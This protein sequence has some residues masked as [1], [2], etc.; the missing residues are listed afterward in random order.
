MYLPSLDLYANLG[1][2]AGTGS[3][4]T[5]FNIGNEWFGF[6]FAGLTLNIPIFDGLMKHNMVQQRKAKLNQV[7]NSYDLLRNSIDL[8][9]EQTRVA[10]TTAV[11]DLNMQLEN[12][13]LSEEVY[14]ITK[15]KYQ[16]GVGSNIEVINADADYK[17]A[18]VNFFQ[19]LYNAL[20]SK[21]DYLKAQGQLK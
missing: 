10:Y 13:N 16:Q 5:L 9:L 6:G 20:L 12:M 15:T 4:A 19:A 2:V 8:E 14:N 21:V 3:G 11:Q 7:Y 17:Q 1:A 18:Q